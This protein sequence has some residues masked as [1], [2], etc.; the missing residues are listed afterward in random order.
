MAHHHHHHHHAE[1]AVAEGPMD[2]AN[3]SL[4][5]ALRVSLSILKFVMVILVI[6]YL[7][8]GVTFIESHEEAVVLRFGRLLPDVRQ[9]GISF[10][11]P[12]PIDETLVFPTKN[13]NT[14][15]CMKH[16][17]RVNAGQEAEPLTAF[18][19]DAGL[20]PGVD[21][22]LMTADRGLIHV[23]WAVEYQVDNLRDYVL[24]VGDQDLTDVESLI[25]EVLQHQAAIV[26]SQFT[27]EEATRGK[28]GEVA[29]Q[30]RRQV[31]DRLEKLGTGVRLATLQIPR[32]SVPGQTVDAFTAVATAENERQQVVNEALQKR[33]DILNGVAGAAH[34]QLLAALDALDLATTQKDSEA[35]QRA[36]QEIEKI[37]ETTVAG[38]AGNRINE[39]KAYY[40]QSLQKVQGEVQR[41]E[42]ALDEYL[43]SRDLFVN[44]MWGQTRR[45]VLNYDDV[46]KY[47][48]PPGPYEIRIK[49]PPDPKIREI[50]ERRQLE[51]E[52]EQF[53]FRS[54]DHARIVIP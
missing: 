6:M 19:V 17:P 25:T 34:E 40:T 12:Y 15:T 52:A 43:A 22:A 36:E 48:L 10:A 26:V 33:N 45:R 4:S 16:W 41:Y 18:S 3:Q 32:S 24:N 14:F 20:K 35:I 51:K 28:S 21:G 8:S 30:V 13:K 50:E 46:E 29:A 1:P 11:F 5:D 54:Q 2:A 38:Q 23:Q 53:K 37:L 31:N 47:M 49:V 44:R 9:P 39:A 7:F 42:A 27:A